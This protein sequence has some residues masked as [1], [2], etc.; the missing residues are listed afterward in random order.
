MNTIHLKSAILRASGECQISIREFA[1]EDTYR[2]GDEYLV[3]DVDVSYDDRTRQHIITGT[4]YFD[5]YLFDGAASSDKKD[6]A[7]YADSEIKE[8]TRKYNKYF[9]W[10]FIKETKV[11]Y[12]VSNGWVRLKRTEKFELQSDNLLLYTIAETTPVSSH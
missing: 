4:R 2:P 12:T 1:R 11:V 8:K 5:K 9:C 7:I 3:K 10:P 6:L